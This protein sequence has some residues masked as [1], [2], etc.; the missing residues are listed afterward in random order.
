VL[1]ERQ[2]KFTYQWFSLITGIKTNML[3]LIFLGLIAK[4]TLVSGDCDVGTREVKDFD[5]T[6]V[7]ISV[8]TRLLKQAAFKTAAFV[9]ISFVIPLTNCQ[10][11]NQTEYVR[12]ID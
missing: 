7:G 4:L 8:F 11:S 9:Y 6:E 1:R 10:N 5:W 2:R 3:L 12:V